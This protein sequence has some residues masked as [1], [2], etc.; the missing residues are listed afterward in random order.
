MPVV[1]DII[2]TKNKDTYT[3]LNLWF[4]SPHIFSWACAVEEYSSTL[5]SVTSRQIRIPILFA[6]WHYTRNPQ[7]FLPPLLLGGSASRRDFGICRPYVHTGVHRTSR[8]VATDRHF[9]FRGGWPGCSIHRARH[10]RVLPDLAGVVDARPSFPILSSLWPLLPLR[11][12]RGKYGDIPFHC[13]AELLR[14][15][16]RWFDRCPHKG[17]RDL[18]AKPF[19]LLFLVHSSR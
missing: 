8:H 19:W 1:F 16:L 4:V 3:L 11:M 10:L 14:S 7:G 2:S 13:N 6:V 17:C 12:L 5:P 9:G 15:S 18:G